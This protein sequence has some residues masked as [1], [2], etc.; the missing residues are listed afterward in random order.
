MDPM[1]IGAAITGGSALIGG[2]LGNQ[3]SAANARAANEMSRDV[4]REQMEFQERMS[5]TA[6]QRAMAD[7]KKA[8]LN[9]IL[10]YSQGG[11]S[12]PSGAN[13]TIQKAD[14][15][16]PI[17]PAV[18]SAADTYLK[19]KQLGVSQGQL[20]NAESQLKLNSADTAVS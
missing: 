10:A 5:N 9:P 7:M 6:Y 1:T 3:Q 4:A 2:I 12:T 11:A 18:N 8:G 20:A 17:A 16:D 13:A 19:G 14:Y 15:H